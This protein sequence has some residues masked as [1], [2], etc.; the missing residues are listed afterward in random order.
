M[1]PTREEFVATGMEDL[2]SFNSMRPQ[3]R[4]V[5]KEKHKEKVRKGLESG[6]D[7]RMAGKDLDTIRTELK[8]ELFGSIWITIISFII[9][10]WGDDIIEWIIGKLIPLQPLPQETPP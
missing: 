8:Q 9:S 10:N 6:Y 3:K 4:R 2:E 7:K 1:Q 5:K